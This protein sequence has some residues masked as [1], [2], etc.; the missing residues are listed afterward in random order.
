LATD[1]KDEKLEDMACTYLA[2]SCL[3]IDFKTSF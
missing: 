3:K 2:L 1:F